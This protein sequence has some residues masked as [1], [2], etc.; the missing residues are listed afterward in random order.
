MVYRRVG[1]K[2]CVNGLNDRL[3]EQ[4][5]DVRK[6]KEMEKKKEKRWYWFLF[7]GP[8]KSP[9]IQHKPTHRHIVLTLTLRHTA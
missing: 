8:S 7:G 6:K 9:L 2:Q 4:S 5:K 3:G 1:F